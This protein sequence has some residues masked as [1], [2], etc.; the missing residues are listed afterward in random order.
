MG[1]TPHIVL[2][3]LLRLPLC[4]ADRHDARKPEQ[5]LVLAYAIAEVAEDADK[6][7][8]LITVAYNES[9]LCLAV[10]SGE[11]RGPGRGLYQLEGKGKQYRGPFIGLSFE[12]TLNATR[13]ASAVLDHSYQCGGSPGDVFTAYG[14]RPCGSD[15]KTLRARERMYRWAYW[16]MNEIVT[17][18]TPSR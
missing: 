3:V 18:T 17:V 13:V 6:A 1:V 4:W 5:L 16:R 10:H 9:R 2:S 7:A 8:K 11:H 12:A 14:A 15:W